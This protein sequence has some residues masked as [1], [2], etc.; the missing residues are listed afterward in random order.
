ML[1][2]E[3]VIWN[4]SGD[5]P[6]IRPGQLHGSLDAERASAAH[7]VED[8]DHFRMYY[9]GTGSDGYNRILMARSPKSDPNNWAPMGSVLER[10]IEEE[11][12][13]IG[14]SF[15]HVVA[16]DDRHWLLFFAGWGRSREDGKLPN[17]TAVAL[18]ED[19]GHH[20]RYHDGGPI[21]DIDRSW[22]Q[23]G[24]GS[25]CV[26]K[27]SGKLRMYYTSISKYF[28]KPAG[29]KTAHE[30]M[31]PFIGL[32]CAE[33]EDGI[34]WTKSESGYVVGPRGF[35]TTPYEYI[36][37]KPFIHQE[38]QGYRMWVNTCGIAYRMRSLV[39]SDAEHWQWNESGEDGEMSIGE[40]G[41][42]DDLQRSYVSILRQDRRYHCWY[43]G[44][45]YGTTGMGYAW[46]EV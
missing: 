18:S 9:W 43:T 20:F 27:M 15:P 34:A 11:S 38:D 41:T 5:N 14:P 3:P 10:Q 44:N 45:G 19:G 36:V 23:E 28:P 1:R 26:L 29:I 37:S 30:G 39:S 6:V 17:R 24:T 25:I 12:N 22:D 21:L 16:L 31:I 32:G 40:P 8:G 46:A 33:S 4:F 13:F 42:F 7:V 35:D 2:S